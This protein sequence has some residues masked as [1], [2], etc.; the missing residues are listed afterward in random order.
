MDKVK[1]FL[2]IADIS[3]FTEFIKI[4]NMK[5]K[6]LIGNKL[7]SYWESHAEKIIKDLLES[8]ITSFVPITKLNKIEGEAAF[9]YLQSLKPR[10]EALAIL[11]EITDIS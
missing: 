6:P 2:L 9:F 1:G 4:H 5:K 7:A 8:I 10:D 3:G 11:L